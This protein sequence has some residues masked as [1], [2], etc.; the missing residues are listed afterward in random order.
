[1]GRVRR[2]ADVDIVAPAILL[3]EL[4]GERH[5][6]GDALLILLWRALPVVHRPRQHDAHAQILGCTNDSMVV[7]VATTVYVE[8][9]TDGGDSVADHLGE[10]KAGALIDRLRIQAWCVGV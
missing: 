10:G 9:V 1:M 3:P 5:G 7:L 4:A 2:R 6:V 8:E